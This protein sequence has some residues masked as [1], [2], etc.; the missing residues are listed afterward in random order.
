[1]KVKSCPTLRNPMDCSLSGSSVHGI[2]Q[3][4]VL[5]WIA[6]SFSRG[7]SRPRIEPGS[8]AL[9]ADALLSEPPG[10]PGDGEGLGMLNRPVV[11]R[12]Y[13]ILAKSKEIWLL[14]ES[15]WHYLSS[16]CITCHV[17]WNSENPLRASS[18]RPLPVTI[19]NLFLHFYH[20]P[21]QPLHISILKERFAEMKA[22]FGTITETDYLKCVSSVLC[23]MSYYQLTGHDQ[24]N[25]R[26][27]R[28]MHRKAVSWQELLHSKTCTIHSC[29]KKLYI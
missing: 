8:P 5:E 22:C 2:F 25:K 16:Q 9:Q 17:F 14:G 7:S 3:P 10:K 12:V 28:I 15:I 18:W 11:G 19:T 21:S 29:P 1:M 4:K 6:I 20:L 27:H 13:R 23:R 26:P 24:S